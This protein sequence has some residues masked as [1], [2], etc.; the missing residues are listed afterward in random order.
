M[1]N[2]G[3]LVKIAN[4]KVQFFFIESV[5]VSNS[6]AHFYWTREILLIVVEH[7]LI[8]WKLPVIILFR[9]KLYPK[10]CII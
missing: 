5:I 8:E 7:C 9:P 2:N 10:K 3:N 6:K 1:S 4:K